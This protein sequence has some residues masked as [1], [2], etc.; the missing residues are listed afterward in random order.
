MCAIDNCL[1]KPV[2]KGLCAKHYQRLRR[3]GDANAVLPRGRKKTP[4]PVR[5]LFTEM[6][7]RTY[8]EYR[9]AMKIVLTLDGEDGWSRAIKDSARANGSLNVSRLS[10]LAFASICRAIRDGRISG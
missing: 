6:S 7:P 9:K 5:N 8:F 10:R 1:R 2:A 4:D 3:R